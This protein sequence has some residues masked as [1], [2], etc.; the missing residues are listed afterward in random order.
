MKNIPKLTMMIGLSGSGKSTIAE[1]INNTIVL[2]SDKIRK[3]LFDDINYQGDNEKVFKILHNR[4]KENLLNGNDIIYDA[5]NLSYKRRRHFLKHHLRDVEYFSIAYVVATTPSKCIKNDSRR[6]RTVG[7]EIILR[8]LKGFQ[9]PLYQEGF[10]DIKIIY[11]SQNYY[12][13]TEFLPSF[14]F[15]DKFNQENENHKYTLGE[16]LRKT[17][18]YLFKLYNRE[19]L[20]IA[21]RY[22]DIGKTITKTFKN[23]NGEIGINAHYYNHQNTS[24]YLTMF[25]LPLL[26]DKL[27][28]VEKNRVCQLIT[29]HMQPFFI[30]KEKT[31]NKYLKFLGKDF[32]SDLIKLHRA[33]KFA[34]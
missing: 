26:R 19:D 23:K 18:N 32:Y 25:Y 2:S 12:F 3:E 30:E 22:H 20:M 29:W 5:T 4:I 33:D 21:G 10:D 34:H 7:K 15:L 1:N 8:Q 16:H 24:A 31:K 28:D 6:Q 11:T 9:F 13:N 17:G 27:S 14:D